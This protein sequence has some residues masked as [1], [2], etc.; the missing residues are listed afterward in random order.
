MSPQE[1]FS[2]MLAAMM[3]DEWVALVEDEIAHGDSIEWLFAQDEADDYEDFLADVE[4]LR[5][6]GS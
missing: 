3:D 2:L 4:W 6:G 5:M 1:K